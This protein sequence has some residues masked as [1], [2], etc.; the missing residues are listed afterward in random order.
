MSCVF[1]LAM[2]MCVQLSHHHRIISSTAQLL[3]IQARNKSAHTWSE[4]PTKCKAHGYSTERLSE[5]WKCVKLSQSVGVKQCK[6]GDG[7]GGGQDEADK[8]EGQTH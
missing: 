1:F 5:V 3:M 2:L 6:L 4:N 7:H 8:A